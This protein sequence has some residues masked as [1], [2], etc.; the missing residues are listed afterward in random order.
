MAGGYRLP[1]VNI[2]GVGG[3]VGLSKAQLTMS[4]AD[5]AFAGQTAR[6]AASTA[7]GSEPNPDNPQ[8]ALGLGASAC[9]SKSLRY[10]NILTGTLD[11]GGNA[12]SQVT[13]IPAGCPSGSTI[14][15]QGWILD[16]GVVTWQGDVLTTVVP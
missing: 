11:P 2:Q 3:G 12:L 6:W 1:F 13:H 5:V 15:L 9:F 14:H 10:A 8:R 16:G 4:H 7:L